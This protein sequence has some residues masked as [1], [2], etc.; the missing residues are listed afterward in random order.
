MAQCKDCVNSRIKANYDKDPSKKIAS[1]RK[2]HVENPEWSKTVLF[3]WH[4]KNKE[5][6]Y[7]KIQKRLEIDPE[8]RKYRRS[9]QAASERKRRAL[10]AETQVEHITQEQYE[11]VLTLNRGLC[12]I[13]KMPIVSISWDH[14]H[15]LSKGGSHTIDNLLPSCPPCNSRKNDAYPFTDK[16]RIRVAT[17][18]RNLTKF[19]EVMP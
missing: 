8:F 10:K 4:Q 18:V 17:E 14:V 9:I 11:E 1:T 12:W 19:E 15:P 2:Y 7:N 16:M 3:E 13:C 5:S 6:R